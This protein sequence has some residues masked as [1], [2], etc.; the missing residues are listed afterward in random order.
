M[1]RRGFLGL[2]GGALAAPALA[3]AARV[4]AAGTVE[5][6]VAAP[7]GAALGG[8]LVPPDYLSEVLKGIRTVA[9]ARDSLGLSESRDI[10][11]AAERDWAEERV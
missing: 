11:L 8:Y 6:G 5:L 9:D 10:D 3:P 2:F 7:V 4:I 1:D